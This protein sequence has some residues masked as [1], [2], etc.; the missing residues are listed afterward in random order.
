M[1]AGANV[2]LN[3]TTGIGSVEVRGFD[4]VGDVSPRDVNGYVGSGGP[5][6]EAHTGAGS[7]D[8]RT[9]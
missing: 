7:I 4:V 9:R 8:L 1:P 2:D 3:L 6:V 5:T